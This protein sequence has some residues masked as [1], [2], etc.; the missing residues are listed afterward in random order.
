MWKLRDLHFSSVMFLC[1]ILASII[2]I[3]F[4]IIHHILF[5]NHKAPRVL[6]YS[7]EI[8][9]QAFASSIFSAIMTNSLIVAK[10]YY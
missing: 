2:M 10:Q 8:Y 3:I 1:G 7:S 6:S 9:L 4:I 5:D